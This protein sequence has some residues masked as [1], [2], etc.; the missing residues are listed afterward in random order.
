MIKGN[1]PL[2]Q[3]FS[4]DHLKFN[5]R[6]HFCLLSSISCAD[7]NQPSNTTFSFNFKAIYPITKINMRYSIVFFLPFL[8]TAAPMPA[9]PNDALADGIN[10]NLA[11]GN[12]EVAA[13]QSLQSIEQNHGTA[14][15][16]EAGVQGIQN[17]LSTAVGDRTQNQAIN[18]KARRSNAAV[19][20]DLN[21]V[22]T[23]QGMLRQILR[24][25]MEELATLRF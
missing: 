1:N 21:K 3:H 22:A 5:H 16:V 19:T 23:A 8:V 7:L 15:Q 9:Q 25:L 12:Q 18:N 4:L 20:T 11:A 13:V 24:S 6:L 10:T 2:G 14:A 17:A